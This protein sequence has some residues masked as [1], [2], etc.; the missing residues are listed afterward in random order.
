MER[1]NLFEIVNGLSSILWEVSWILLIIIAGVKFSLI[2]HEIPYNV[3]IVRQEG[4][5][6]FVVS[7]NIPLNICIS[8]KLTKQR[9]NLKKWTL[10]SVAISGYS[11]HS[12]DVLVNMV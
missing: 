7:E 6:L 10:K 8:S 2:L 5:W 12:S 1:F 3:Y 4:T 11:D 9:A